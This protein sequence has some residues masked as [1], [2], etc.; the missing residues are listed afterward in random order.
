[1]SLLEDDLLTTVGD[2]N[3]ALAPYVKIVFRDPSDLSPYA[4]LPKEAIVDIV[5]AKIVAALKDD[6]L[7]LALIYFPVLEK[8][9]VPLPESFWFYYF[10]TNARLKRVDRARELG[11]VYI[12]KFGTKGKYYRQVVELTSTM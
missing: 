4:G 12:N 9:D 8:L 11:T 2:F 5:M 10:E 3:I 7:E 6:K 1:M